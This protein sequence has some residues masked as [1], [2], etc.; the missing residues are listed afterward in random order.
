MA[1]AQ[2]TVVATTPRMAWLDNLRVLVVAGVIVVG[3]A[4]T[5]LPGVRRVV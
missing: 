5:R 4:L 3:C 1:A 2:E